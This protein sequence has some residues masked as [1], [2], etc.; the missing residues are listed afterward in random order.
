M[1]DYT[2]A[3]YVVISSPLISITAG[4]CLIL[5]A[6]ILTSFRTFWRSHFSINPE[7]DMPCYLPEPLL[8][9][10]PLPVMGGL[11]VWPARSLWAV[12]T[13]IALV[14]RCP[15]TAQ[16]SL[17]VCHHIGSVPLKVAL[18]FCFKDNFEASFRIRKAQIL[19]SRGTPKIDILLGC[20]GAVWIKHLITTLL[21]QSILCNINAP[22]SLGGNV[23]PC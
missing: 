12:P 19:Y 8:S 17:L 20:S 6:V 18:F 23:V 11:D 3:T 16:L 9:T 1:H 14:L 2:T 21:P 22:H 5:L 10:Y 13:C 4:K 15:V 7:Q